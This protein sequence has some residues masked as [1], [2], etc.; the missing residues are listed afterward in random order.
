V[1]RGA[2]TTVRN[3]LLFCALTVDESFSYL[4]H[5]D[6][7]EMF[8]SSL[9]Y[10]FS[11]VSSHVIDSFPKSIVEVNLL[12]IP[13]DDREKESGALKTK[14]KCTLSLEGRTRRKMVCRTLGWEASSKKN[15]LRAC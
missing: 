2:S 9:F 7:K 15:L 12:E 6:Q 1:Y 10:M 4:K 13:S 3:S 11:K 5:K 8:I 14:G